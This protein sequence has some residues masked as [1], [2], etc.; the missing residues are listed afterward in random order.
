MFFTPKVVYFQTVKGDG[1]F[2]N[3]KGVN[4]IRFRQVNEI[5]LTKCFKMSDNFSKVNEI[6]A[7]T[8]RP[9][10]EPKRHQ[11]SIPTSS[12]VNFCN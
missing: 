10:N 7:D 9:K 8:K 4:E 11:N 1:N 5:R 2:V 3:Q 12:T 6:R